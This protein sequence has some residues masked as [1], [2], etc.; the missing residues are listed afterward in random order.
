MKAFVCA[1]AFEGFLRE[2]REI[3]R[4]GRG[5]DRDA[6]VSDVCCGRRDPCKII[7]HLRVIARG[8]PGALT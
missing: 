8:Q 6:C 7:A 5:F 4:I 3:D 2:A 1:A